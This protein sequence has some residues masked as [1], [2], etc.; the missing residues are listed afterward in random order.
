MPL[1]DADDLLIL[2]TMTS[3]N[4][5]DFV[6]VLPTKMT[7]VLCPIH[8]EGAEEADLRVPTIHDYSIRFSLET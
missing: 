1:K 2:Q 6:D 7:K 5:D 8:L 3:L 4:L